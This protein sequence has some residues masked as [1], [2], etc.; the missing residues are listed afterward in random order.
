MPRIPLVVQQVDRAAAPAYW[1]YA[2]EDRDRNLLYVGI[3][4][5]PLERAKKHVSASRWWRFVDRAWVFLMPNETHAQA[6]ERELIYNL[7]PLF[8]IR[9]SSVPF[10]DALEYLA[11]RDAWDL[12]DEMLPYAEY[13]Q[14][15]EDRGELAV[16][17]SD[18]RVETAGQVLQAMSGR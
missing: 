2:Y 14:E 16:P 9:H 6:Y 5:D 13:E 3:S 18:P 11:R 12:V 4:D 1:V 15:L 7:N 10:R 8:N 17:Q